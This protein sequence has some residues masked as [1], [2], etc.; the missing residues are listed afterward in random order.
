MYRKNSPSNGAGIFLAGFQFLL[1]SGLSQSL[2][3]VT[4]IWSPLPGHLQNEANDAAF[5]LVVRTLLRYR[6]IMICKV[7]RA[8]ATCER[9]VLSSAEQVGA[10]LPPPLTFSPARWVLPS[11][12]APAGWLSASLHNLL[13]CI[14]CT[15]L[16]LFQIKHYNRGGAWKGELY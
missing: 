2:G 14:P 9:A 15:N 16:L 8:V 5:W 7:S 6:V 13:C 12:V 1:C 3:E 10:R 4:S 11:Q